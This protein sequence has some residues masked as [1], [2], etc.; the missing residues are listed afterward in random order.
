M[1]F[2]SRFLSFRTGKDSQITTKAGPPPNKI[3]Q[4]D[5]F[6]TQIINTIPFGSFNNNRDTL[7]YFFN[8][9]SEINGLV[10]YIAQKCADIPVKHVK[11]LGNKKEKEIKDSEILKLIKKP[12]QFNHG[13]QYL[14]NCFSSYLVFGTIPINKIKSI[15]WGYKELYLFPGNQFYPIPLKSINQYGQPQTGVDWRFNPIVK[16]RLFIDSIPK[17]FLPEDVMVINDSNL[18]F[19]NGQ[20]MTG[21]S[22]LASAIRSIK[23]LSYI[24]DTVNTLIA[25]KG[26]EGIVV[27]RLKSGQADTGWDPVDKKQVETTLYSYGLTD[28]RRPIAVTEKDLG[29]VRISVPIGDFMPIEIKQHEFRTL[30]TA[31]LFPSVLLNDKEGSIYNNVVLAQKAFYTDCAQP[32]VNQFWEAKSHEL[33][34]TEIGEALRPDYSEIEC[35][36]ADKKLQAETNKINDEVWINRYNNNLCTLN[37]MLSALGM[38]EQTDGNKYKKEI[39]TSEEPEQNTETNGIEETDNQ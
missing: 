33:G 23:T 8:N 5:D 1:E 11:V 21:Q 30:A 35:L 7:L 6:V 32:I 18:S 17:D 20:Y 29:F 24:Y 15:G 36:Q 27:N 37:Q 22:R 14:I 2:K 31:L 3:A 25:G 38:P 4:V 9:V 19:A 28:G 16:Y 34:L 13:R 12:N 39:E 26:A 10:T